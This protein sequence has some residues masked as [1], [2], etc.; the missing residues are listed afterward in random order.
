MIR[1]PPRSTLFPYTT[2]F[3][4]LILDGA[5]ILSS[6]FLPHAEAAEEGIFIAAK[7]GAGRQLLQFLA[8]APAQDDVIGF[9]S[10]PQILRNF[11]YLQTPFFLPQS[12]ES[13]QA[14]I[15]FVRFSFVPGDVCQL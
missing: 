11:R 2:L 13:A 3:R 4:S 10:S 14:E 8:V 6:L 5:A 7:P 15:L 9:Q 12:F 1:R